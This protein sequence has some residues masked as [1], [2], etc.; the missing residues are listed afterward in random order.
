[1]NLQ[2]DGKILLGGAFSTYY[3][4][5]V[6]KSY[7]RAN[8][9]GSLE[10]ALNAG[11]TSFDKAVWACRLLSDGKSLACG[12]FTSYNGTSAGHLSR[13]HTDG[14]LDTT[15]NSGGAGADSVV[16]TCALQSDGKILIS[17]NFT[18]YN[19]I[20]R[21]AIARLNA[22]GTLDTSFDPGTSANNI[23]RSHA[24]QSDGKILVGGYFTAYNGTPVNRIARIE[25]DGSLDGSFNS[26]SYA[27]N[28][29]YAFAFPSPGKILIVGYFTNYGGSTCNAIARIYQ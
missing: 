21:I 20:S 14:N 13:I 1:V 16:R 19:G 11:G 23:I 24:V 29:V 22:D 3:D 26:A 17:G 4:S 15:F 10:A 8:A 2:A 9:D 12:A 6:K 7:T 28:I 25:T 18:T 27:D 5:T